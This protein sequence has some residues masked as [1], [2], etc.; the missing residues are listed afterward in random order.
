MLALPRG[1]GLTQTLGSLSRLFTR[2]PGQHQRELFATV[3]A[4]RV[5]GGERPCHR[6]HLPQHL[7]AGRKPVGFI[8]TLEI[9]EIEQDQRQRLPCLVKP[10][11]RSM[12]CL[13]RRLLIERPH[14]WI[15]RPA[16]IGQMA[17][18]PQARASPAPARGRG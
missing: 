18:K 15:A 4:E 5:V 9:I 11:Y 8:E 3:T 13:Q 10:G 12:Q 1:D 17:L 7:V 16:R 14:Q 2:G 6:R